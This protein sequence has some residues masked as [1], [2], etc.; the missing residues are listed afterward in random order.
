MKFLFKIVTLLSLLF[1]FKVSSAEMPLPGKIT[2]KFKIATP[3]IDASLIKVITIRT[4][5]MYERMDPNYLGMQ[6]RLTKKGYYGLEAESSHPL[7]IR[8]YMNINEPVDEAF[9][10]SI[11]EQKDLQMP[12][13]GGGTKPVQLNFVFVSLEKQMDT[14]TRKEFLVRQFDTYSKK[15]TKNSEK[16]GGKNEAVYELVYPDLDKPMITRNIPYLSSHLSQTEGFL[17]IETLINDNEEYAF[18][19]TYSKDALNNDKIWEVLS[20]EKW[21]TVSKEGEIVQIDP[22][23]SFTNKGATLN[24]KAVKK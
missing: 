14:I 8:L 20:K 1:F 16:W 24:P 11:V 6:L 3:P 7:I 5:N 18:R 23:I 9:L 21:T 19:I 12:V 22:Q 10:K 4:E 17:G 13:H 15:F 2:A